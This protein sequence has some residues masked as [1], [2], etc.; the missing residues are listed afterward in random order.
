MRLTRKCPMRA[1]LRI[2]AHRLS[3]ME[4]DCRIRSQRYTKA[5]CIKGISI[6]D[7]RE[8]ILRIRN[9]KWLC[10]YVRNHERKVP[11]DAAWPAILPCETC[12]CW[13]VMWNHVASR[14]TV[15]TIRLNRIGL[16]NLVDAIWHVVETLENISEAHCQSEETDSNE[17]LVAA[18][19]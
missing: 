5:L 9:T 19:F 10:L 15:S 14:Q 7:L 16:R 12:L 4:F 17:Y 3:L 6:M 11:P 8:C 13:R 2:L 1:I 18:L